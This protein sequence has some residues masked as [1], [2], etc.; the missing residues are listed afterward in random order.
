MSDPAEEIVDE[1][2][3]V[4]Q[5]G[6]SAEDSAAQAHYQQ[7]QTKLLTGANWFYWIAGL[8]LVNS[9]I[10]LVEGNW[11]FFVGLGITQVV[12]Y[13]AL[14]VGKQSPDSLPICKIV[15]GVFTCIAAA[16]FATFGMGGRRRLTWV[17]ICGM[18]LY[19]LDGL[20]YLTVFDAI[21]LKSFGFHIFALV[22]IFGGFS[23]CRQLNA[24]DLETAGEGA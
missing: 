6:P 17:F 16:V 9:F 19:A 15:A 21:D 18:L 12:N 24:L 23:A 8:S 4:D 5:H 20:L 13:V 11:Q 10:L 2:E 22:G 7:L 14:E 1:A 3:V